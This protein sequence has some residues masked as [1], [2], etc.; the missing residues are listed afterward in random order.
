MP[1]YKV[2]RTDRVDYDEFDAVVVRASNETAALEVALVQPAGDE[3]A[4][5][6]VGR[7]MRGFMADGSN[8]TVERVVEDG[9]TEIVLGSFN[10]G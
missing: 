7:P 1:L 9:P 6:N 8:A 5:W 10:A 2:S 3:V 4:S